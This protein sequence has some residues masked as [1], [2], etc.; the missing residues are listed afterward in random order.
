MPNRLSFRV[1]L[2]DVK[3]PIWRSFDLVGNPTF[4]DLHQA[5]QDA[6]GWLDGH[7]YMFMDREHEYVLCEYL[8]MAEPCQAPEAAKVRV[9]EHLGR[10][11]DEVLY[12]Y[13]FGDGWEHRVR[14][15]G[16][17]RTNEKFKRRLTGGARSFPL[18]DCGGI[19]G[20]E[21]CLAI[22]AGKGADLDMDPEEL[23]ER[24]EWIGDWQPEDF[25]LAEWKE[26]FD[27]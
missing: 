23:A 14:L 6:C 22:R 18:E 16:K 27:R 10:P 24:E 9:S 12:L 19:P 17:T 1:D 5:I 11:G 4:A 21:M 3:P 2:L 20:Y 25:D 26:S 8:G 15:V 13:D 7:L